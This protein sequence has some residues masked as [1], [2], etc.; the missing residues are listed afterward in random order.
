MNEEET[1]KQGIWNKL[2]KKMK[3]SIIGILIGFFFITTFIVVITAPLM[4]IG[5]IDIGRGGPANADDLNYS[6]IVASNA[7]WWPIGSDKTEKVGKILF[8]S[9]TPA[10]TV[11]SSYFGKRIDP[12]T[13]IESNHSGTDI[14]PIDDTYGKTNVIAAKKGTV[15]Y[16]TKE[17]KTNCPSN[18]YDESCGGSGYGNYIMIEHDDGIITLYGHLYENSITVTAGDT[19]QQGQVIAKVGSSGRSTGTHLHFEV[20]ENGERVEPLNYI[21]K[22]N[23]RPIEEDEET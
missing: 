10:D 11:I 21:S 9:G 1:K 7:Y 17:S 5:V 16:P 13:K 15:L 2:P 19:V 14:A 8:A 6:D 3:I 22:E 20:K 12:Y 18:P 23:P 4:E